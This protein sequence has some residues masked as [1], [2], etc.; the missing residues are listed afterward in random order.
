[1]K[2]N[3]TSAALLRQKAEKLLNTKRTSD[4]KSTN[5]SGN[6]SEAESLRLIH[7]LQVHQIELEIINQELIQEKEKA[8][9]RLSESELLRAKEKAEANNKKLYNL[10]DHLPCHIAYVDT[11]TLR[12][13]F[14]NKEFQRSF[15]I[16]VNEIVGQYVKDIIGDDNF[17]FALE[18]INE[19]RKGK[20]ASYEA[21]FNLVS[22]K[23]WISVDYVPD[24]DLNGKVKSIIVLA[25]DITER[26]NAEKV[27]KASEDKYRLLA[28]NISDVIWIYNLIK[29]KFTYI[30]PSVFQLRGYTE[31]EA[32]NESIED[33]LMP[34]SFQKIKTD[35]PVRMTEFQY[36]ISNTYI[37][38]VRQPC[39]DGKV[40]WIEIVTK[41]QYAKDGTIEV[42]GVSRDISERKKTEEAL[43]VSE[44]KYRD[45][46]ES[47]MDAI[48]VV[49]ME[50]MITDANGAF[51]NML[52]YT[53]NELTSLNYL[54]LT[55]KKWHKFEIENYSSH[56]LQKGYSD[57][58]EKEYQ[59]KDGTICPVELRVFLIKD[60]QNLP[61]YMWAIVRNI[62]ER[63][64]A[65]AEIKL[66]N[67]ELQKINAEKDKYFSIIAH[68]LRGPL[69][70]FLGLTE[71]MAKGLHRMTL[72]E[73][74]KLALLLRNS[75]ANIFRLLGNLLEWSRMQRGLTT[76]ES[77]SFLLMPKIL[78]NMV[79]V[80][81]AANKKEITISYN[82]PKYIE[83]TA[84]EKMF[85]GIIRNLAS[86]AV[87]FTPKGGSV[88][89][90]AK[91]VSN[92]SV[93]ITIKDTGIGM[94][95]KMID[96][97][98]HLDKNTNRKGT[99]GEN[100]TGLGLIICKDF[101]EKNGGRLLIESD[102]GKGS[103]FRFTIPAK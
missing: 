53:L 44:K 20:T 39:K 94:N 69:S 29:G 15:G 33:A 54:D 57:P 50:G 63:K 100:S 90:S 83:I 43:T 25:Y 10:A 75:A 80:I 91:L 14:V 102:E 28:E 84:D 99:D 3:Q 2:D 93:E 8:N 35:L 7:E 41:F 34:E 21:V 40:K 18:F 36:D 73:I 48:V 55:P 96:N 95:K 65:E 92:K 23:R 82:I 103:I 19:V 6:Q 38:Q 71:L 12:Y 26:K 89:I 101:I 9:E 27:I 77:S 64:Q 70:G 31:T 60:N 16:P 24:F 87:K 37:D 4:E 30:S 74:E 46:Y 45:L 79:F 51:Q 72:A 13:E 59:R 58:Y 17:Q 98:F 11:E 52:G 49:D 62:S 61:S 85:G 78:E 1:M 76:F 67:E 81:E 56:I 42:L 68:D 66:K 88:K 47:I 32:M 86:N 5:L 97:L 22:G